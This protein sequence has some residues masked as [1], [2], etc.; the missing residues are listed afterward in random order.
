[1]LRLVG[2][3][4]GTGQGASSAGGVQAY[5]GAVPGQEAKAVSETGFPLYSHPSQ[6]RSGL[7]V[8]NLPAVQEKQ[9]A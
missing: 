5:G 3:V 1:M 4:G 8:R 7:A 2:E 6:L 9:E